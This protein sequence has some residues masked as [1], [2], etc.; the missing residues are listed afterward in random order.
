M[1]SDLNKDNSSFFSSERVAL[2]VASQLYNAS[3]DSDVCFDTYIEDI[4]R[5]REGMNFGFEWLR[6]YL[7]R[8]ENSSIFEPTCKAFFII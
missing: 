2:K 1:W 3:F 7:A 6:Q 8:K 5:W 4:T